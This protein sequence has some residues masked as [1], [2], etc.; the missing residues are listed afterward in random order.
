M[1]FSPEDGKKLVKLAR[2][3][4]SGDEPAADLEFDWTDFGVGPDET[5]DDENV[6][7]GTNTYEFDEATDEWK[8]VPLGDVCTPMCAV[9]IC[10]DGD[11][12]PPESA[13]TGPVKYDKYSK[14]RQM[15]TSVLRGRYSM[16]QIP[17]PSVNRSSS[18]ESHAIS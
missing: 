9:S 4:I 16:S 7:D 12:F 5:N 15:G 3:A 18:P 11:C 17:A 2:S 8:I 13:K 14:L 6:N 1:Q 10:G